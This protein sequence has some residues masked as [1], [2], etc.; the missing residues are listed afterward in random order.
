[1]VTEISSSSRVRAVS[2]LS[3]AISAWIWRCLTI[4]D[5]DCWL[6]DDMAGP[7]Q[8]GAVEAGKA[9]G[10]VNEGR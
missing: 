7:G 6:A 5:D 3:C 1:M 10:E 9:K 4:D 2:V 8:P